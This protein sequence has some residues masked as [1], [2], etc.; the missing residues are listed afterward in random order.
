MS[1]QAKYQSALN[2]GQQFGAKNGSVTEEN[3]VLKV[4]GT[5]HTQYEK[6]EI[7]DAIKA[8]GGDAPTDIIADIQVETNAY[9][10]KYT[11]VK[12]DT[13]G[14]I[15]KHFYGEAGK[16]KQ[17]FDANRNILSDADE[18]EVGQ[19]LVIPFEQ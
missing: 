11:V 17:I 6:N 13:L 12:G 15:S 9:F 16:Y 5:V 3:G 1:V 7:W 8:A 4:T 19:E 18:I 2:L 10:A 14:K